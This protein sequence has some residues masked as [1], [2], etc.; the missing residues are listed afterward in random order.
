MVKEESAV[1]FITILEEQQNKIEGEH[2]IHTA[3]M[4]YFYPRTHAQVKC[5]TLQSYYFNIKQYT[6]HEVYNYRILKTPNISHS[7][8][9][10]V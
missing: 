4:W 7:C 2:F 3:K 6:K 5:F 8:N 9:S 10:H 1:L